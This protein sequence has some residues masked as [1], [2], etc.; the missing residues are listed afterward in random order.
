MTWPRGFGCLS[1]SS[2]LPRVDGS[3]RYEIFTALNGILMVSH[4]APTRTARTDGAVFT[5][6][7]G[8]I[9]FGHIARRRCRRIKP[10]GLQTIGRGREHGS[11]RGSLRLTYQDKP[12]VV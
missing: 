8:R 7:G 3:L 1:R 4:L 11:Q 9:V 12:L 5:G 2:S 10:E 6:E